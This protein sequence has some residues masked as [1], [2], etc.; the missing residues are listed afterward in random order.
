MILQLFLK[1]SQNTGMIVTIAYLLS[2]TKVFKNA[3]R[4]RS[5]WLEKLL[6]ISIFSAI[7][8]M[9]TYIKIALTG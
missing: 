3:M 8:I 5:D 7:G 1:L 4:R 2:K 9:G 6:L